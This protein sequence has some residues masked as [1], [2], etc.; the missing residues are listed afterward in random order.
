MSKEIK[1]LRMKTEFPE[2]ME[3]ICANCHWNSDNDFQDQKPCACVYK[4][5]KY[6]QKTIV[7]YYGCEYWEPFQG[8]YYEIKTSELFG[9]LDNE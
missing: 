2:M 1:S 3:R 4:N 6:Y 5:S 9:R 7:Y 8:P